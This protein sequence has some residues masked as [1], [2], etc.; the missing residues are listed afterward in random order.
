EL[1]VVRRSRVLRDGSRWSFLQEHG[2]STPAL[3]HARD[4]PDLAG[5]MVGSI[6]I[7][8]SLRPALY[9]RDVHDGALLCSCRGCAVR[10]ALEAAGDATAVPVHRV[11][12]AAR[13]LHT[14]GRNLGTEHSLREA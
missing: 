7:E 2:E 13:D 6:G 11:S 5:S 4:Q 14:G 1:H 8:R 9:L 3:A 10:F 12:V